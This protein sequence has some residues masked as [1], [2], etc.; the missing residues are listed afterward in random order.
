[1]TGRSIPQSMPE[2][3]ERFE[4]NSKL[5]GHGIDKLEMHI[6]CPF[7]AAPDFMV[8]LIFNAEATWMKGAT[9]GHC[10]RSAKVIFGTKTEERTGF[11]LVQTG[12][13]EQPDWLEPKLKKLV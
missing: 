11:E 10:G 9:C 2:F 1:M 3:L 8:Y 7:C 13:D 5:T 6:P 12:G 4:A